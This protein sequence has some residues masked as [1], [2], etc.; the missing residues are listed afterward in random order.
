MP[1]LYTKL[2]SLLSKQCVKVFGN[3]VNQYRNAIL[4]TPDQVIVPIILSRRPLYVVAAAYRKG[5]GAT[6]PV[7][8]TSSRFMVSR[9]G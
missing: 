9:S 4:R 8:L 2:T 6:G 1:H 5:T 7:P 3:L